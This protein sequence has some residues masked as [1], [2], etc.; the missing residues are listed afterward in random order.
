MRVLF[1]G[2]IVGTPGVQ[3]VRR[4]VPVLRRRE[5]L[6]LVVANAENAANGSGLYPNTFKQLR[7]AGVDAVTLGDHIYKK[8]DVVPLL[9]RDEPICKLANFPAEAPG[10][11]FARC[12]AADGTPL[13]V[14]SLLG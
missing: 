12:A 6:D 13:V 9:E 2:D 1:I 5:G 10:R 8:I 3:M 4:A 11:E 7:A 14:V